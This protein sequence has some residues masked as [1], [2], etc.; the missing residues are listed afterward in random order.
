QAVIRYF[1]CQ[2]A[3]T[4][5]VPGDR[6]ATLTARRASGAVTSSWALWVRRRAADETVGGAQGADLGSGQSHALHARLR[7][8]LRLGGDL[9]AIASP[10]A[11]V[12]Q[13]PGLHQP[14]QEGH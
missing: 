9:A 10:V 13:L 2:R 4:C 14:E 1:D 12:E 11:L 5:G 7:D 6:D 3:P 8:L